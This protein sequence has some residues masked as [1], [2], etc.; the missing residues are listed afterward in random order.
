MS[1][2]KRTGAAPNNFPNEG[3][4]TPVT[5]AAVKKLERE[6]PALN[7]EVH[8]TIGGD[9]ETVVHSSA[10]AEREGAIARGARRLN[11]SSDS[12]HGGFVAAEPDARTEYIRAQREAVRIDPT[13]SVERAK[14]PSR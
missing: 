6:R 11:Q 8:Y 4:H 9:V 2:G 5:R 7:S 1:A 12:L 13:K 3:Q 10:N 14:G